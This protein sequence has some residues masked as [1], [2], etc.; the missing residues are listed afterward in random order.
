M[1]EDKTGRTSEEYKRAFWNA[2]RNKNSYEV[3][4]ALKIG[5]DSEGGYL[6]PDEFEKTLVE[7]L[8]EE[9]ILGN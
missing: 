4:N 5:T 7:G 6:V 3:Q 9:N 1:E 2:M 8:L